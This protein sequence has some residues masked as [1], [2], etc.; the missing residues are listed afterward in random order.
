MTTPYQR[1]RVL[2]SAGIRRHVEVGKVLVYSCSKCFSWPKLP[3]TTRTPDFV[4]VRQS[5][6]S[7]NASI[8]VPQGIVSCFQNPT[9]IMHRYPTLQI[10]ASSYDVL[11]TSKVGSRNCMAPQAHTPPLT[12]FSVIQVAKLLVQHLHHSRLPIR[13]L[14]QHAARTTDVI[15]NLDELAE[16]G[17]RATSLREAREAQVCALAVFEDDEEF[18]DEGD[19]LELEIYG[20][21]RVSNLV[22]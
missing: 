17:R 15:D 9:Q 7:D 14:D 16:A 18:D 8:A 5:H 4:D 11:I 1:Q 2:S 22:R 10:V 21:K 6:K 13:I 19:G 3:N 20:G 12:H